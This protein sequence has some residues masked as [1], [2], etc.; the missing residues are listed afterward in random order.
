MGYKE[1]L[2]DMV[3]LINVNLTAIDTLS[4]LNGEQ[5]V[6]DMVCAINGPIKQL[7]NYINELIAEDR[8]D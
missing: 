3:S 4:E 7:K 1:E 2:K 8:A 6:C 5:D